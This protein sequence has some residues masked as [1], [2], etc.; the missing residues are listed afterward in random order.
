MQIHELTNTADLSSTDYVG[1]DNGTTTRR[2]DLG[3]LIASI[4]NRL[5]NTETGITN[6]QT[7]VSDVQGDVADA[8]SDIT[9]L[10]TRLDAAESSITSQGNR[11][12]TA[13]SDIDNLETKMTTAESNIATLQNNKVDMTTPL[14][15]FDDTATDPLTDD[16]ALA[17]ALTALGILTDVIQTG[18]GILYLKKLLTELTNHSAFGSTETVT[19]DT[20][21]LPSGISYVGGTVT[22]IR[23][24]DGKTVILNGELRF[25]ITA[26]VTSTNLLIPTSVYLPAR[27][28]VLNLTSGFVQSLT[29]NASTSQI[30]IMQGLK[31]MID[32]TGRVSLYMPNLYNNTGVITRLF[33]PLQSVV[34]TDSM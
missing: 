13:E 3:A 16:G 30:N 29:W 17:N 12:T 6:L 32:T 28:S 7:S 20:S 10:G 8:Q 11:L 27:Q 33:V 2:F 26:G 1:V 23:S 9:G 25:G 21:S 22:A 14:L 18:G 31:V 34:L 15:N 19:V 24:V 5:T 4:R